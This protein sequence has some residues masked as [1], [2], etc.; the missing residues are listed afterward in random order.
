MS[1]KRGATAVSKREEGRA[2]GE[3]GE[4]RRGGE[5]MERGRERGGG[6]EERGREG[7]EGR[8]AL[9]S[10]SVICSLTSLRMCTWQR[11]LS[12]TN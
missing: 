9:L 11:P 4:E 5:G 7:E 2:I 6:G 8:S 1:S 10:S 12:N 3:R